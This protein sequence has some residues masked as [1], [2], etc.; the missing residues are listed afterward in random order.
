[1]MVTLLVAMDEAGLIGDGNRL[2]WRLP[3]DLKAFRLRTLGG[4]VLMGRKTW[5]S[6]PKWRERP[7]LDGRLNVVVTSEPARWRAEF[8][9]AT[10]EAEGP[11]FVE[12]IQACLEAARAWWLDQARQEGGESKRLSLGVLGDVFVIG[13]RTIYRQALEAGLVDRMFITHVTGTHKGDVFF[14]AFDTLGEQ[15]VGRPENPKAAAKNPDYQLFEY[16]K[17][18]KDL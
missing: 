2:P 12:S 13:G 7:Y 14:P 6:L 8:A 15:W 17:K 3:G 10:T 18:P 5:Q 1:M 4:V 11:I 9:E 16:V